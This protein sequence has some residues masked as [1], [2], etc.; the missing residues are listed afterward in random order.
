MAPIDPSQG[1]DPTKDN[2]F[3]IISAVLEHVKASTL[4]A[5]PEHLG[6]LTAASTCGNLET[7]GLKAF[8]QPQIQPK[9][10]VYTVVVEI[11]SK[12]LASKRCP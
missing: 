7:D 9:P 1:V 12:T 3:N 6:C 4:S 11:G 5:T 10:I 2:Y 8:K